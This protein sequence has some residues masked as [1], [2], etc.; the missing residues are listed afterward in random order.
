MEFNHLTVSRASHSILSGTA[1]VTVS[2]EAADGSSTD[3]PVVLT[4]I[5]SDQATVVVNGRTYL[6]DCKTALASYVTP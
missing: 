3:Y 1:D 5:P 6:I 4:F 2:L